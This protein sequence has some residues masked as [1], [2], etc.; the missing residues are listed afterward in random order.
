M[1]CLPLTASAQGQIGADPTSDSRR[2][3]EPAEGQGGW[4]DAAH[5]RDRLDA[6]HGAPE[7]AEE[8]ARI[9]AAL[10]SARAQGWID[11]NDFLIFGRQLH[12]TEL[13][14]AREMRLHRGALPRSER[15]LVQSNLEEL[16]RQISE[17]RRQR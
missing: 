3:A 9:R 1:L 7:F 16:I 11:H 5:A 8:E 6:V 2:N 4:T 15:A 13:H 14:E 10:D 17:A 12:Q